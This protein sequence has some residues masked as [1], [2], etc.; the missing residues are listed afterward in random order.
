[1]D[2][3]EQIEDLKRFVTA[4]DW[5]GLENHTFAVATQLA[6]RPQAAKIKAVD[7]AAYGTAILT[8][9]RQAVGKVQ[10]HK[11]IYFEYDLDNDWQ[12]S[13]FL[14]PD[15]NPSS[16]GDDDWACRY[17]GTIKGPIQKAL[18]QVYAENGFDTTDA[19][20]GSTVYLIG[21]TV[22]T[23][24]RATDGLSKTTPQESSF[25]GRLLA[26]GSRSTTAEIAICIAFHDQDPIMRVTELA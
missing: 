21:R 20:I 14:C 5:N 6:G 18:S 11:A 26:K 10:A 16:A 19:A 1:M 7:L 12:G 9:L 24:G 13:F 4:H 23:F 8:G 25:F 2:I 15:Y 17:D 22:A 3:F